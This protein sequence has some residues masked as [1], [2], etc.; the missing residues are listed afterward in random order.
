MRDGTAGS[1]FA[2]YDCV[3]RQVSGTL[4]NTGHDV[5]LTLDDLGPGNVNVTGGPLSYMYRVSELLFHFGSSEQH[6]SEH[7][8]NN[9]TFAAEVRPPPTCRRSRSLGIRETLGPEGHIPLDLFPRN[10][11]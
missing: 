7:A 9:I 6:G 3:A 5:R 8:I 10:S 11:Q 1:E 4:V 2:V